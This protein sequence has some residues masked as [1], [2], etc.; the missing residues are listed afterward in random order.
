MNCFPCLTFNNEMNEYIL[1]KKNVWEISLFQAPRQWGKCEEK[2]KA[3]NAWKL[4]RDKAL[5]LHSLSN[6]CAVPT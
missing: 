5:F 4:R 6:F 3:K 2:M 1:V